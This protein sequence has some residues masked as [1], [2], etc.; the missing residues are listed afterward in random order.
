M[1]D[2]T[3]KDALK[4]FCRQIEAKMKTGTDSLIKNRPSATHFPPLRFPAVPATASGYLP[5]I[6][7]EGSASSYP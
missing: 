1:A 2:T 6:D 3:V 5:K 7:Y 4:L